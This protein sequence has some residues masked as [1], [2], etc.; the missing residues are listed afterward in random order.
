MTATNPSPP[1]SPVV[2]LA[3]AAGLTAAVVAGVRPEQWGADTPCTDWAVR[4]VVAHLIAGNRLVSRALRNPDAGLPAGRPPQPADEELAA[5]IRA[6]SAELVEAFRVPGIEQQRITIPFGQVP[7][8][9]VL[10]LRIVEALVH[11]W[12]VARAT[13][14]D[15]AVPDDLVNPALTFSRSQLSNIPPDRRPFGPAQPIPGHRPLIDQL[16]AL[17]G[18]PV[19]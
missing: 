2:A 7:G 3:R 16:A 6:S 14:Q 4:D 17:L 1:E 11:G 15:L 19:S 8:F 5:E 13:G 18:R 9:V 12:D 10:Q